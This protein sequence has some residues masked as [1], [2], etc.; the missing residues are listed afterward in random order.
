MAAP[1]DRDTLGEF[2]II[3]RFFAPLATHPASLGLSDD[4]ALLAAV[5]GQD[6]VVAT[7]TLIE[8]V[9][10][11]PLDP[12]E[13]LGHKALA[14]NL[15]D[16]ASMGATP[17]GY[18]LA[19]SLPENEPGRLS[20]DWLDRFAAG[21]Q[22]LQEKA[23]LSLIGG[24][25]T[26]TPGPLSITITAIGRLPHGQAVLRSKAKPDDRLY[27]SGTVG[28]ALLGLRVL[29]DPDLI[30]RWGLSKEEAAYLTGRYRQPQ[31][32][33]A[34]AALLRHHAHAAID[35]SDGLAGDLDKICVASGLQARIETGRV[36]LS[37]AA[38]K[39]CK[40]DPSLL[41]A[42][43]CGG[44]DYEI[45]AA[46]PGART[47]GFAIDAERARVAVTC[48]GTFSAGPPT[49]ATFVGSDDA[50]IDLPV[51]SFRHFPSQPGS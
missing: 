17:D 13:T 19:L 43:L 30:A 21:L 39:A 3:A 27:L 1:A 34:L 7:D 25:T 29:Q 14:V 35:I 5:P 38:K 45:L 37:Q 2:D 41:P 16:L 47:R 49:E 24:D 44:D 42:L 4:A 9:H 50:P 23:G 26:A 36:P 20:A 28:D 31:P 11:L 15:S 33:S 48:L 32:P 18:L 6:L 22:Q 46:I 12:P 10:F 8:T 51:R 40:A